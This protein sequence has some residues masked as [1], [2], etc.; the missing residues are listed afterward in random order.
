VKYASGAHS[1]YVLNYHLCWCVKYRHTLLTRQIGDRV[2]EVITEIAERIGVVIIAIETETDHVHV[3]CQLKPTHTVSSVLHR[4]KGGSAHKIFREFP[5]LR[6]RLLLSSCRPSQLSCARNVRY[7]L[8]C[9]TNLIF[10]GG[11][12]PM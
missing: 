7:V 8:A 3:L 5:S 1:K 9:E 4:F 11:W 2:K 12:P 6:R 10:E